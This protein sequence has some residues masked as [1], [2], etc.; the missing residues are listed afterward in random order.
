MP[1]EPEAGR[2]C[3]RPG[4]AGEHRINSEVNVLDGFQK[5]RDDETLAVILVV[6]CKIMAHGR[7]R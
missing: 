2:D 3:T 7:L 4:S 6:S 5:G 1:R